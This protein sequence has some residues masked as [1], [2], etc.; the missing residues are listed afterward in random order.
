MA[1]KATELGGTVL[2]APID[3]PYSRLTVV[4]DPQRAARRTRGPRARGRERRRRSGT[5]RNPAATAPCVVNSRERRGAA[6]IR[7]QRLLALELECQA[8][9]GE[10]R[11]KDRQK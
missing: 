11:E 2:L 1:A 4:R 7:D 6:T 8:G 5:G 9:H 10:G 3:A